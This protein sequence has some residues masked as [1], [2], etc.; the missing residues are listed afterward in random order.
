MKKS[1]DGTRITKAMISKVARW[2]KAGKNIWE[3]SQLT[4]IAESVVM[5]ITR[6]L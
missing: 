3:I 4:G 2:W 1:Q 6:E 5:E